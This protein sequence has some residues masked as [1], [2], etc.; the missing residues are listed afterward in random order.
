MGH[1]LAF[2]ILG[3]AAIL[4]VTFMPQIRLFGG[5]PDLIMLLVMAWIITSPLEEAV[6][7]AFVGGI[8]VDL[9]SA[10]PRGSSVLGLLILVFIIEQLKGQLVDLNIIVVFGLVLLGTLIQQITLLTILALNGFTIRPI[11][12]FFYIVVPSLIYNLIFSLPAIG[13]VRRFKR[14]FSPRRRLSRRTINE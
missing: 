14:V 3:L 10:A 2:P 13:I 7:W 11:E 8:A 12:Q 9:L 5:Q 4:Q 1:F 6:T